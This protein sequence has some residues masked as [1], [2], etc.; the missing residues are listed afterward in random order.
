M[1]D[2]KDDYLNEWTVMIYFGSDNPLAPL[3]VSQLKDLKDA[4]FQKNT[5]VLVY[6]DPSEAGV[7]ARLF[8]V[9]RQ[10]KLEA[11]ARRRSETHVG[12][13]ASSFVRDLIDDHIDPSVINTAAG[14]FSRRLRDELETPDAADATATASLENFL[15]FCQENHPAKHYI[16]FLVGHGMIV[17]N[18]KFL[19]D[20]NPVTAITLRELGKTLSDFSGK[21]GKKQKLELVAMHSC[22]MS[23][24]EVA[25][26]LRDAANYMMASQGLSFVNSWPYRQLFKKIFNTI[27]RNTEP[28]STM[29]ADQIQDLMVK[30]H[31]AALFNA[32]DFVISG[33]SQ[34]LC[35]TRL[36]A[37]KFNALK[38]H[39]SELV[40]A[41]KEGL[42]D[43]RVVELIQLAHL[44]AQSFWQDD[45]TDLADFCQCLH[46]SL[47]KTE[48]QGRIKTACQNMMKVL[49]P[50]RSKSS[51]QL[52]VAAGNA[53]WRSQF[54]RGLSIYFPWA[55][56]IGNAS[57]S[58]ELNYRNYKFTTDFGDSSWLSFLESYFVKTRREADKD[59]RRVVFDAARVPQG[60]SFLGALNKSSA[61][62]NKSSGASGPDCSCSSI[63]N[64][65][66]TDID[67]LVQGAK[68]TVK[69]KTFAV[70][71]DACKHFKSKE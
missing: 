62:F 1:P 43:K 53:G 50:D 27:K 18:D 64:Y 8:E 57:S 6:F 30:L 61:A 36:A 28:K 26:E 23:S 24:V 52:I 71:Q 58:F 69:V 68:Q 40:E 29:S 70:S 46:D 51:S 31:E 49:K 21:I 15:G 22:S 11:R 59:T 4:G 25:Y 55:E 56:P 38:E 35:L 2:A 60:L 34:D 63:K 17:G 12:D 9:N 37:D 54:A 67:I 3:L 47:G 41:L 44:K 48:L 33:Y 10:R 39:L 45:Y 19:P 20:D 32:T 42:D 16:L 65:P 5:K 66:T 7:P 13:G 14:Q